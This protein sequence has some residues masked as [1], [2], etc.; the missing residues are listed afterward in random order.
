MNEEVII[1]KHL[2]QIFSIRVNHFHLLRLKFIYISINLT[3]TWLVNLWRLFRNC[4]SKMFFYFCAFNIWNIHYEFYKTFQSWL[5]LVDNIFV[6]NNVYWNFSIDPEVMEI[7]PHC[8]ILLHIFIP[9][10]YEFLIIFR[11]NR[12]IMRSCTYHIEK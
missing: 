8:Y 11:S 5:W 2:N 1:P 3:F 10:I 7:L 12:L 4:N 9:L 6:S